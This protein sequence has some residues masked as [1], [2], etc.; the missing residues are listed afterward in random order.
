MPDAVSD[1]VSIT[2]WTVRPLFFAISS[3]SPLILLLRNTPLIDA[4][5]TII[6]NIHIITTL[7]IAY[8]VFLA[9]LPLD[10]FFSF[11]FKFFNIFIHTLLSGGFSITVR[12][13]TLPRLADRYNVNKCLSFKAYHFVPINANYIIYI[14]SNKKAKATTQTGGDSCFTR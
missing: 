1:A 4:L 14:Y 12:L 2:F 5:I 6:T 7:P 8:E 3:N 10:P 9:R 13:Q 11:F